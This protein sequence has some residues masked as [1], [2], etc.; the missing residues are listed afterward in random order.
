MN[1]AIYKENKYS[2]SKTTVIN[3]S[4]S[5]I[6]AL[7]T[8]IL[9]FTRSS[10]ITNAFSLGSFG[11][12]SVILGFL[13]YVNFSHAGIN[14]VSAK[15]LY[16]PI[17][18]NRT[19]DANLIIANLKVQY[20]KIGIFYISFIVIL[21]FIFPW[22]WE[23]GNIPTTSVYPF[24]FI[25][26]YEATLF[27]LANS[28]EAL[29]IFGV[30]PLTTILLFIYKKNFY[31][32][33]INIF[34]MLISNGIIITLLL[35]QSSGH[36]H[37]SFMNINIIITFLLASK[38]LFVLMIARFYLRK[39]LPWYRKVKAE[40]RKISKNNFI[41]IATDFLK[42]MGTDLNSII[43]VVFGILTLGSIGM[44]FHGDHGN[45]GVLFPTFK[46][47]GEFSLYL[48]ILIGYS[49]IL[50]SVFDASLPSI[51]QEYTD[52]RKFSFKT[53]RRYHFGTILNISF[54]VLSFI[55]L[56]PF[57]YSL[58]ANKTTIVLNLTLT[59]G[60][61]VPFIIEGISLPYKHLMPIL[62]CFDKILRYTIIKFITLLTTTTIFLLIFC[63]SFPPDQITIALFLGIIMGW[64]I[65]A[66]VEYFLV[67]KHIRLH[68]INYEK[69]FFIK[70]VLKPL[71]PIFVAYIS[72]AIVYIVNFKNVEALP[73]DSKVLALL[74][75]ILMPFAIIG[76]SLLNSY[77]FLKED[78]K[79]FSQSIS[80][81]FRY[82][83][84][85]EGKRINE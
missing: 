8:L 64:I 10:L 12:L 26:W 82:K 30:T 28:T 19:D 23:S 22:F 38:T 81:K 50:H 45:G 57:M 3:A 48:L 18:E 70:N 1:Q 40:T 76:I 42:Q 63:F 35:L 16:D 75:S 69:N 74:L 53:F 72:V 58:L 61:I 52:E 47:V 29:I 37:I 36:I 77:I 17:Y 51:A 7:I 73:N 20:R 60:L 56:A 24:E 14:N 31:S 79:F 21:A 67:S 33:F 43:F 27:I 25:P 54:L 85:F 11:F 80:L 83:D 4:A 65:S 2:L 84:S 44:P 13:P 15:K 62:G 41:S 55:T 49:E 9:A 34:F 6:L 39:H 32:T 46:A 66:I 59:I 5:I 78:F 68:I 71:I